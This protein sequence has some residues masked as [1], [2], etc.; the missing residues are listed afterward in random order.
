MLGM[1]LTLTVLLSSVAWTASSADD[2]ESLDEDFLSYLAEFESDEDDWT[3]VES[4]PTR[5]AAKP[6]NPPVNKGTVETKQQM[7]TATPPPEKPATPDDG[8]K[9]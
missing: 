4:A 7:K 5:A 1:R 2:L 8:N 6:A 9:R 3:I